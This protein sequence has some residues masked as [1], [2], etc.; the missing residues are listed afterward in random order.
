M[1]DGLTLQQKIAIEKAM[2]ET[3]LDNG[4]TISGVVF[5][6]T[7]KAA[8][9]GAPDTKKRTSPFGLNIEKRAIPGVRN[10]I[11]VASGKGGVG[12]STISANL[13]VG[14]S[15]LG[16]RVGLM[17]CDVYGPSA[18][19]LFGKKG[20]LVVGKDGKIEPCEAHG[21]RLVSF[22]FFTDVRSPVIWRGPLVSK[23]VEQMAYDVHWGDL[24]VL[25]VDMPPGTGD[26][27]MTIAE[28]L[29]LH[30]AI[31][32]TTPQDVALMDAHKAVSMFERLDVPIL[33][34]VENMAWHECS[35]CSHVEHIFGEDS[36]VEFIKQRKLNLLGRI[37]L[38]KSLR[39]SAD[40]GVPAALNPACEAGKLFKE[41]SS[42]IAATMPQLN[43]RHPAD[44]HDSPHKISPSKLD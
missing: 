22:G 8:G 19:I 16:L 15:Q 13:A 20:Q 30:G 25:V 32:V 41:L 17:D 42:K 27:Q 36:F 9:G 21:V 6:R 35:Q 2:L 29:P 28:K 12:K 14:L 33:G 40:S 23:A 1:S 44:S 10:V 5:T 43:L 7:S 31:V 38:T 39:E 11:I 26:V 37:P 3:V 34:V 18:T 24:E 4:S